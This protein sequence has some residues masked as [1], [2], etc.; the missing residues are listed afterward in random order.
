MRMVLLALAAG[1]LMAAA[2]QAKDNPNALASGKDAVALQSDSAAT[3]VLYVCDEAERDLR[4]S[5][6]GLNTPDFVTAEQVLA[7]GGKM[8]AAPK[9]ITEAE[10]RRLNKA[11]SAQLTAAKPGR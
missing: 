10:L 7:G 2:P 5:S 4:S 3:K 11:R 6:R 8:W 1:G 9:C